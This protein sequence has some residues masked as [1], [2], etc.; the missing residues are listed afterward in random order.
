M[1]SDFFNQDFFSNVNKESVHVFNGT[2]CWEWT[3]KLTRD[4]WE[5]DLPGYGQYGGMNAH[6]CLWT[7]ILG[8]DDARGMVLHHNC[9]F[10]PWVNPDHMEMLTHKEHGARHWKRRP[11]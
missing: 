8:R 2:P 7:Q 11:Q 10:R 1:I 3:G 6:R 5:P 4:Y 9:E